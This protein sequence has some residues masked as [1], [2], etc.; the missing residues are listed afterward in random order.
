MSK[1]VRQLLL[2]VMVTE[3]QGP[4]HPVV[5][6]V[7]S[8]GGSVTVLRGWPG[9]SSEIVAGTRSAVKASRRTRRAGLSKV[10][11]A[12]EVVPLAKE[13]LLVVNKPKGR[14]RSQRPVPQ[15]IIP[16]G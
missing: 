1:F 13:T 6:V 3:V 9:Q 5:M 7:T 2:V 12:L 4:V 16:T 8:T 15:S 11:V 14:E 10:K